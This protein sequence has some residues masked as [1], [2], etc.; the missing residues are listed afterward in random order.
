MD[1]PRTTNRA[2]LEWVDRWAAILEPDA[3]H[4]CDGS[5]EEYAE[6]CRRPAVE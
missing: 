5:E 6:L 2:L 4:W 1:T 3:I